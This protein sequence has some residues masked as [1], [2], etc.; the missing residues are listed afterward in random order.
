MSSPAGTRLRSGPRTGRTLRIVIDGQAVP[1]GS[2]T[3]GTTQSGRR[4][5]RDSSGNRGKAWRHQVQL[6]AA[7]AFDDAGI[8]LTPLLYPMPAALHVTMVFEQPRA[9]RP[10]DGLDVWPLK[11]PDV[12]KTARAIEDALSGHVWADDDQVVSEY[13]C[14]RYA[15]AHRVVVTITELLEP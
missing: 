15:A 4:Y 10:A 8:P 2:K 11:P 6:A 9:K 12:L 7:A 3:Q 5:M 1:A 13:I 14:K